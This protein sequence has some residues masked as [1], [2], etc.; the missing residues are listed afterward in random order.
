M[1]LIVSGTDIHIVAPV[2]KEIDAAVNYS[3]QVTDDLVFGSWSNVSFGAVGTNDSDSVINIITN[4][5]PASD[6][7]MFIRMLIEKD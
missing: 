1:E 5:T 7:K 4:G 3:Y 6:S 2:R